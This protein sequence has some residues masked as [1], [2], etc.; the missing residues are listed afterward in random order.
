MALLEIVTPKSANAAILRNP[1]KRVRV[2]DTGLHKLLDDMILTMREANGAGLAAPQIGL[3]QRISVI[4]WPDDPD[5]PEETL[6]RYEV[7]N[8]E[9]VK[10]KGEEEGQEGCLSLPGL[11]AD[12]VR[13]TFLLVKFQDRHGKEVRLKTYDWLARIFQH[14]IDHLNG[15]LMTDRAETLYRVVENEAGEVEL[16]PL[17]RVA[18]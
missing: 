11:A 10:A 13:A 6:R 18:A 7:I 8:P 15:V 3:D 17:E 2:F 1:T 16:I 12:V 5:K 9:I 14:E 4:E